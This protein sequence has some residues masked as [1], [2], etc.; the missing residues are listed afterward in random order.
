MNKINK[1][2]NGDKLKD[3]QYK[4]LYDIFKENII[5]KTKNNNKNETHDTLTEM[6]KT[7]IKK[8]INKHL[9]ISELY[10]LQK[11]YQYYFINKGINNLESDYY[12]LIKILKKNV[13]L[14]NPKEFINNFD[15][16][17]KEL[18]NLK[19]VNNSIES[20]SEKFKEMRDYTSKNF[21]QVYY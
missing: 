5:K 6:I 2:I 4:K 1:K 17:M 8:L 7:K 16:Y 13:S 21:C 10:Q 19:E 14:S 15:K 9:N 3:S 18:Y 12:E 20:L 11:D